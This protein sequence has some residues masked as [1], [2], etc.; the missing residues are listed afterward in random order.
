M[1]RYEYKS[2]VLPFRFGI[3]KPGV[4]DID[5]ALNREAAQGW[6]LCQM[7][8]SAIDFGRSHSL[9]MVLERPAAAA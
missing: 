7:L 3:F 4:P 5:A 6:R 9:I 8:P 2:L 1:A